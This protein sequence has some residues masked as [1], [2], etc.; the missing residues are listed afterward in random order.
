MLHEDA[1]PKSIIRD[2]FRSA[3]APERQA[4]F[5]SVDGI[6]VYGDDGGVKGH[7]EKW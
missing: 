7:T 3:R 2:H 4:H 1:I 6:G 5:E